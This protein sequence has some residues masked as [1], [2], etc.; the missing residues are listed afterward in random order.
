MRDPR[1]TGISSITG[2][3]VYIRHASPIE[4]E[5]AVETLAL[6]AE[7]GAAPDAAAADIAVAVED[8]RCIGFAVLERSEQD[9]GTGCIALVEDGRRRGIGGPVLQHLLEHSEVTRLFAGKDSAGS[10]GRAGFR[11]VTGSRA[12][13]GRGGACAIPGAGAGSRVLYARAPFT[14]GRRR[15][16][17]E[18][19]HGK[20]KG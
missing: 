14:H 17:E 9:E 1:R 16:N 7:D 12:G 11:R 8:D 10:L 5:I 20:R 3:I 19:E 6:A 18:V 15:G 4:R 13:R 2:R